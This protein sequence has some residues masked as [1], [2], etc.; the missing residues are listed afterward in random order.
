MN[1]RQLEIF[2]AVAENQGFSQ[3]ARKLHIAQS[4]VSSAIKKLE[5]ELGLTLFNRSDRNITLTSE[6]EVLLKHANTIS[7]QFEQTRLEMDELK[8][9]ERGEVRIAMSAMMGS[10]YFPPILTAFKKRYPNVHFYLFEAGSRQT[11]QMLLDGEIDIGLVRPNEAPEELEVLPIV[12]EEVVACVPHG[13]RFS[14]RSNIT[15]QEFLEE[16]LVLFKEGYFLRETVERSAKELQLTPNIVFETDLIPLMKSLVL[17]EVG[18]STSLRLVSDIER[19][20]LR[21][22]LYL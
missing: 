9:L 6:G 4:A 18:I 2:K 22:F 21:R 16:P 17:N 20:L 1:S 11:Q 3:A 8:G 15:H 13:H 19:D 12:K 10:Y 7:K 5:E 14:N